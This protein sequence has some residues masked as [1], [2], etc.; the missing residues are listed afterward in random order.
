MEELSKEQV[1]IMGHAF[2]AYSR[3]P[4]FRNSYCIDRSNKTLLE[5]VEQ[6]YF[7]GP[8]TAGFLETNDAYFY[9]TTKGRNFVRKLINL[10][11][12]NEEA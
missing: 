8:R 10:P 7:I 4:G 1:Q 2:G 5:L 6:G 9:L 11:E 3:K 12:E